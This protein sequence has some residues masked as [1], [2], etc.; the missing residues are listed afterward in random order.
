[1]GA[2]EDICARTNLHR[3][4]R[5]VGGTQ[6][7]RD[8]DAVGSNRRLTDAHRWCART[9]DGTRHPNLTAFT[10]REQ[11]LRNLRSIEGKIS[12]NQIPT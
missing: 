6:G 12:H 8:L 1:L 11:Q 5:R 4:E 7:P 2:D 9:S 3:T 10:G